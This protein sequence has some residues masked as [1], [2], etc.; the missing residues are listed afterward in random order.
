M[1]PLDPEYFLHYITAGVPD[2]ETFPEIVPVL[3][4]Q[5]MTTFSMSEQSAE[6]TVNAWWEHRLSI[7]VNNET[8]GLH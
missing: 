6:A 7:W 1:T 5:V 2:L 8:E 4:R 3:V